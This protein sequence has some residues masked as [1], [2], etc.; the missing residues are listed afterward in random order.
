MV[1]KRRT[2][3]TEGKRVREFHGKAVFEDAPE[4]GDPYRRAYLDSVLRFIEE[5]QREQ[6]RIRYERTACADFFAHVEEHRARFLKML[7][8]PE[9]SASDGIP[10]AEHTAL[11][12]DGFGR[13]LRYKIEVLPDFW[14]YGILCIPHGVRRAP[15]VIAQHGGWGI[16]E[17]CCDMAGSNNYDFFT[18]RALERGAVVFA[19][20]L[21]L[22]RFDLNTGEN[23]VNVGIPFRRNELDEALKRLG[24]SITGLE[25]LCIRRSIDFLCTLDT[26]DPERI[27]MMGLSYGGFYSL[28]TAAADTRIKAIYSA[29]SF[30]DRNRVCFP[31]WS[32]QGSAALYQDAEV[33]ALCAPRRLWIDVGRQDAVFDYRGAEREGERAADYYAAAGCPENFVYNLWQGGHK[34]DACEKGFDFFFDSL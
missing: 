17:L 15:L 9:A 12:E 34:F 30:N 29:A 21:L 11:G 27:G 16:P 23:Y 33:A 2:E 10:R 22:W 6:D 20:Q 18:K 14:F 13:Y 31:D 8:S 5:K 24:M 3:P 4:G 32:W 7:G 19:P 25:I 28:Y 1:A 26:V